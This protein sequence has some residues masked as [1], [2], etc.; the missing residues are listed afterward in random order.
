MPLVLRFV[1]RP[2]PEH[3]VVHP[4]WT[5][6][7]CLAHE[8]CQRK[9][10]SGHAGARE[11]VRFCD[12]RIGT[13]WQLFH[14]VLRAVST[15]SGSRITRRV[16]PAGYSAQMRLPGVLCVLLLMVG[17]CSSP[18][19]PP[20]STSLTAARSTRYEDVL[21]LFAD[22]RTFQQPKLVNGVPDYSAAAMAAQQRDLAGYAIGW[23]RSIRAA[24]RF[25]SRWTT[26]SSARR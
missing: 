5:T 19:P 12:L 23:P 14:A 8:S 3:S 15:I 9:R 21:S 7:K 16:K 13:G 22:W 17:G 25:R 26:T 6:G 10:S 11:R 24:G 18:P 1:P 4:M 2:H 20:S